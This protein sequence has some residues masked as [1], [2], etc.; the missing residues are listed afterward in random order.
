[1][2]RRYYV[3]R[4]DPK[5]LNLFDRLHDALDDI[6]A[7]HGLTFKYGYN[8]KLAAGLVRHIYL[9]KDQKALLRLVEDFM[10]P[11]RYLIIEAMTEDEVQ[12]LASWLGAPLPFY[13]LAELQQEA[14]TRAEEEPGT[15]VRLALG[16]GLE[17]DPETFELLSR[18]LQSSRED[19]RLSAAEGISLTQWPEF[20]PELRKVLASDPSD[21]LRAV[22]EKALEA[23][24]R[25][26]LAARDTGADAEQNN[27]R[28]RDKT[29]ADREDE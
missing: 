12:Q 13:T 7:E 6:S 11:V 23:C 3:L 17:S 4:G 10:T 9:E 18:G 26:T 21:T 2:S 1:M 24:Q 25:R 20:V 16:S 29:G 19:V 15:L 5:D 28:E 27:G 22:T 14:R 8:E